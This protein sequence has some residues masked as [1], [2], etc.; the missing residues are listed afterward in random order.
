MIAREASITITGQQVLA[1]T[2]AYLSLSPVERWVGGVRIAAGPPAWR[3]DEGTGRV[4]L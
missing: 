3:S 1:G 2:T 4:R